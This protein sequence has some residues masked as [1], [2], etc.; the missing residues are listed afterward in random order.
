MHHRHRLLHHADTVLCLP[1]WLWLS[2]PCVCAAGND[3]GDAPD[4]AQLAAAALP[5]HLV[6]ADDVGNTWVALLAYARQQRQAAISNPAVRVCVAWGVGVVMPVCLFCTCTC[7][8][9]GCVLSARVCVCRLCQGCGGLYACVCVHACMCVRLCGS[10][11][12][13]S[14]AFV[15]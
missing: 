4:T 1:A 10:V 14:V 2:P 9:V 15:V 5:P 3:L 6:D 12:A 13:W 11:H 8:H 7:V